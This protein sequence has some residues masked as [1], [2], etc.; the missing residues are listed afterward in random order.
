MAF[1]N[2]A[3]N[4]FTLAAYFSVFIFCSAFL[5]MCE[6]KESSGVTAEP[7]PSPSPVVTYKHFVFVANTTENTISSFE[8]NPDTGALISVGPAVNTD[9]GPTGLA[10]H[11]TGKFLYVVNGTAATTQVF[12]INKATG[13]L[14]AVGSSVSSGARSITI[15]PTGKFAYVVQYGPSP[16]SSIYMYSIDSS[17]G[18]LTPAS[19]ATISVSAGG[20]YGLINLVVNPASTYAYLSNNHDNIIHVY[21]INSTTGVLT[22]SSTLNPASD[23]PA[24]PDHVTGLTMNS[25]GTY[26]FGNNNQTPG[27]V[28]TYAIN[29]ST[30]ALTHSSFLAQSGSQGLG[31]AGAAAGALDPTGKCFFSAGGSV[32]SVYA[33]SVNPSTGALTLVNTY[34]GPSMMPAVDVDGKFVYVVGPNN[35]LSIYSLDAATC[36][37]TPASPA[38]AS[39]GAGPTAAAVAKIAQ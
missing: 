38:T 25:S 8:E 27:G 1:R 7:S 18:A 19:P 6:K 31:G 15:D 24:G 12:S 23:N 33:F 35:N 5:G 16:A 20:G 26:I 17:T 9:A 13:A 32:L 10:V 3:F 29:P 2:R 39:T 34:S 4:V 28:D 22:A 11:P 14:T 36:A 30:G 37:L 21:S